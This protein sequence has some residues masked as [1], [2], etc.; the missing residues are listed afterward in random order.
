MKS[1][2]EFLE[3]VYKKAEEIEGSNNIYQK[4]RHF[5]INFK[6]AVA[7]AVVIAVIPFS[8]KT[9]EGANNSSRRAIPEGY[10]MMEAEE[11]G[12][13]NESNEIETN[14]YGYD[15]LEDMISSSSLIATGEITA[16][17][18]D[19]FYIKVSNM[20][21]GRT[22]EDIISVSKPAEADV[23]PSEEV[24]VFLR[25][26]ETSSYMLT[27]NSKSFF[28]LYTTIDNNKIFKSLEGFELT[29]EKLDNLISGG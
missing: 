17:E 10:V 16:I 8:I 26:G 7:A 14:T 19:T 3:G 23:L 20:L 25:E 2:K 1:N 21:K 15:D 5:T 27:E 4:K 12:T 9:L 28:K 18:E 29:L 24:L 11:E 6:T 13:V 22:F